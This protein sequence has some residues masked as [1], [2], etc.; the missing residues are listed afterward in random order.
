MRRSSRLKSK[1]RG[2]PSSRLEISSR[3]KKKKKTKKNMNNKRNRKNE[4][5]GRLR[6][7][8]VR[9]NGKKKITKKEKEIARSPHLSVHSAVRI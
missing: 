7:K 6:I 1:K 3:E 5:T 8:R 9:T 4:E 2:Y